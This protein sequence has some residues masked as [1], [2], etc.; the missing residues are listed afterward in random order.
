MLGEVGVLAVLHVA[1]ELG[2]DP[3]GV[4]L[5]IQAEEDHRVPD[6]QDK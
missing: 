5:L 6:I 3:E 1:L 4:M 2:Q